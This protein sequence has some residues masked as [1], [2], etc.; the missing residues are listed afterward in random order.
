MSAA[1]EFTLSSGLVIAGAYADK[2]R[3]TVFAQLRDLIKEGAIDPKTVAYHVGQLNALLYRLLVERIG[4]DKGD[5]V[6]VRL[7]YRVVDGKIEWDL[8]SLSVE[9]FKRVP[10]EEVN[11]K[12]REF[13]EVAR[14]GISD[15]EISAEKLGETFDGD[16]VYSIQKDGEEVGVAVVTPVTDFSIVKVLAVRNPPLLLEKARVNTTDEDSIRNA[17]AELVRSPPLQH[18]KEDATAEVIEDYIEKVKMLVSA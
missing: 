5:V 7:N 11:A 4:T 13:I 18:L 9:L 16:L 8:D 3:R 2:I 6:R 10:D 14:K 15:A 1:Q 12:V 17:L